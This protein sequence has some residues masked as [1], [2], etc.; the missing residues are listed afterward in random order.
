MFRNVS[1]SNRHERRWWTLAALCV[2]LLVLSIDNTILNVALPT[3]ERDLEASSG[4]LQW[5]VD[6]YLL[7]FAGLLLTM[8]ALGDRFG[9]RTALLSGLTIFGGASALSALA[10]SAEMLI[11]TRALMGVGAALIMPATLSI[12][13]N[14]FPEDE[15]GKAIGIW[16]GVFGLG[17]ALGPISGGVLLEHF[18]WTSVFLVNLPIVAAALVAAV[19]LV[20]ESR[21]PATPRVDLPGAG[22]SMLGLTALVYGIVDAPDAGWTAGS[23]LAALGLAAVTLAAFVAWERRTTHPMLD[24]ALFRDARF[25]AANATLTLATFSL[26]GSIFVLTQYLQGVLGHDALGA[27]LRVLPV[28]VGVMVAAPLSSKV[29]A[30]VGRRTAVVVGMGGVAAGLAG[31]AFVSESS[32]YLPL[33]VAMVVLAAGMG[34][35]MAPATES[36][37]SSLPPGKAGVGSAMNDTTRM[38]GGALGVAVLGSVLNTGYRGGM[39]GAPEVAGESLG[40]ALQAGDAALARLAQDAFVSG[41]HAA[42]IVAAAVALTGAVVAYAFLPRRERAEAAP[43]DVVAPEA[44]PA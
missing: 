3:I 19:V 1:V 13:T 16:A 25:T 21:D 27:G 37:M 34:T 36:V 8:G 23:T 24:I 17:I 42:A 32:G 38:V 30:R 11:A 41:M 33:A 44:A 2:A 22:L 35:A 15:R 6:S 20:P 5:I 14:V 12:V 26:F 43:R 39:D 18:S 9:R 7:V 28:A 10:S 29:V 40:A 4:Q 31:I